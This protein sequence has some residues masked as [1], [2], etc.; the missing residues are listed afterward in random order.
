[1]G[2]AS[3]SWGTSQRSPDSGHRSAVTGQRSLGEFLDGPVLDACF[4]CGPL[5]S[6]RGRLFDSALVAL[7]TALHSE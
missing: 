3:D 4:T 7:L 2:V 1:M 6:A 5:G